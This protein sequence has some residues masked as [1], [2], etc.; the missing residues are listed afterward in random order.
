MV[1]PVWVSE[2]SPIRSASGA[3]LTAGAPDAIPT[4]T[5]TDLTEAA[6]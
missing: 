4:A 2:T 6:R 3:P 5:D 1:P